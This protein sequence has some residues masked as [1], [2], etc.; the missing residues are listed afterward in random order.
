MILFPAIDL[1]EGCCVRLS[2]G[3]MSQATHYNPDPTAQ[4]RYFSDQGAQWLHVV[5]L[6]GAFAGCSCNSAVIEDI[7][8]AVDLPIQLGGG[9][10]SLD[11]I[12]FWL[13]KGIARIILGT[14]AVLD[15]NLIHQACREF[16]DRIAVGLDTR[17]GQVAIEGWVKT[18]SLMAGEMLPC[19]EEAG[20]S[21]IIFTDIR[22]DGALKG[23]NLEA[24]LLLAEST[25]IP[26]IASGGIA[27]LDDVRRL[28]EPDCSHLE[29]IIIGR[30][31]YD[32][33]MELS[34]ALELLGCVCA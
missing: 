29:G 19:L 6:D 31:L 1:K 16:P 28:L 14:A 2:Q 4:A 8:S 3:D 21:A 33:R 24:T 11:D 20:V 15:P 23:I 25:T 34:A 9:I 7:L 32:G 27:S 30:S 13:E 12:S 26:V 18:C 17:D 22:R 5:D 10:R